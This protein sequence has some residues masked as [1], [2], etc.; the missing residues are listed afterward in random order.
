[1]DVI[2]S[3]KTYVEKIISDP[4]LTGMKA[5]VLDADTTSFVS[6]VMSQSHILQRDVFLVEQL[7]APHEPMRHV[8]AAVFVRPTAR[9]VELLRRELQQPKYS[10][11]HIFFS[12]IAPPE[13]LE[14]LAEAD[15]TEVVAQVQEYYADY[16]AVNDSLFDCGLH[17]SVQLCV[18]TPTTAAG[19]LQATAGV[20]TTDP[21]DKTTM[22]P[23]QLFQRSVEG[24]LS[25]LLSMKKRPAIRYAKGSD[26]A[27]KLAREVSARMQLEQDGLFDFR[28]PDV[29]Q[30]PHPGDAR[31]HRDHLA[32]RVE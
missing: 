7:G 6:I 25:L 5:L 17:H 3:V 10:C 18:K 11:Y 19:A 1:M 12:N 15:E 30:R 16:L 8:K 31:C 2:A 22:T 24:L 32:R 14:K 29:V 23:P 13:A 21:V 27:E 28:R 20:L 26:V 4:Q 9:N